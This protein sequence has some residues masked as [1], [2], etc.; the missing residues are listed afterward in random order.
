[1][2]IF[3]FLIHTV[4]RYTHSMVTSPRKTCRCLLPGHH[5]SLLLN[6]M[7]TAAP[8]RNDAS[9]GFIR[10]YDQRRED[11]R[12]DPASELGNR[13]GGKWDKGRGRSTD[14]KKGCWAQYLTAR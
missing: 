11:G 10:R 1:M 4:K 5:T 9:S 3:R 8:G 12:A 7:S 2:V 14:W 13:G 6:G